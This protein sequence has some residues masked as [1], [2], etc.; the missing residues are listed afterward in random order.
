[1]A[2]ASRVPRAPRHTYLGIAEDQA[3]ALAVPRWSIC[4]AYC[5]PPHPR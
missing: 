2:L 1:L 4:P 3:G 5:N